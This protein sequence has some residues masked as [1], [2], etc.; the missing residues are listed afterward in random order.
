M[1]KQILST[2]YGQMAT[3]KSEI[4]KRFQDY[5]EEHGN[6]YGYPNKDVPVISAV[7]VYAQSNF[8]RE[9]SEESRSY[10]VDNQSGKAFFHGMIGNS[11]YG[12]C[13]DGSEDGIRLDAYHWTIEKCYFE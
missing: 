8:T 2:M 13:L 9:Y 7:I 6:T 1:K 10:R 12:E 3:T 4:I 11:I 5:N